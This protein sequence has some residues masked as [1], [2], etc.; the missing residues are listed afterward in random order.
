M[1]TAIMQGRLLPPVD[2]RIQ[3]FPGEAWRDELPRARAAGITAIEW[4]YDSHAEER[5]PLRDDD[6]IAELHALAHEHGVRVTSICADWFME[7]PLT[8]LAAPERAEWR[9]RLQWLL[10]RASRLGAGH[11]MVPFVDASA[12]DGADDED[13]AADELASALPAAERLGVGLHV[14]SSLPPDRLRALAE[15][16]PP[17]F[18]ITYDSGNSASLGYDPREELAAYGP[19]VGSLH[20][21][22]RV[23]GGTTVPLGEGDADLPAVFSGLR[24]HGFD[25]VVVLQVARGAT[26][27]EVAWA[28]ENRERVETLWEAAG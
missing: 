10:E 23:R 9:E 11:V 26:G 3:A 21:K 16:L 7:H 18:A 28:A 27:D 22:D 19:R 14:E 1:L 4:I 24:R 17:P 2:G 13:L 12:L 8:G 5:N 6:G 25:G 20:V 15:R